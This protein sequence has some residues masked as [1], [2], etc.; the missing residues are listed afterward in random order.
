MRVKVKI[1]VRK[2]AYIKIKSYLCNVIKE[3]T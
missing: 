3:R 1:I 2:Y